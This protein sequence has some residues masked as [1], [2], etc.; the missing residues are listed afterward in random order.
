MGL[1]NVD[2]NPN[3]QVGAEWFPEPNAPNLSA[4]SF[5]G[6][7]SSM[8]IRACGD[9]FFD[10]PSSECFTGTG[11]PG[12]SLYGGSSAAD[13]QRYVPLTE[14]PESECLGN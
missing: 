14:L 3:G 11:F 9:V 5:G 6:R 4:D 7:R 12:P 1:R 13:F 10:E 2:E 8:L